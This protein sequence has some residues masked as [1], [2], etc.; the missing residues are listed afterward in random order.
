MEKNG[1]FEHIDGLKSELV[2][3]A[4]EIFDNP[5][6]GLE[7][8]F[9]SKLLQNK[10]CTQGFEVNAGYAGLETAFRAVWSNGQGGPNIGI[11]CEYDG[12]KGMGHT[13]GHHLQGP[14]AIGAATALKR[15]LEGTDTCCTITVYGTPAEETVG[16]KILMAAS[17]CFKE[18]DVALCT[19]AI[20]DISFVGGES[21]ALAPFRVVFQGKT[22]HASGAP[23]EVRSAMD[24]MLLAF[25]G[26]E[27]MREHVKD[28]T[29]VSYNIVSGT[30]SFGQDPSQAKA[31]ISLRTYDEGYLM[32]L[33]RRLRNII[34]GACLM[35]DTEADIEKRP[36]YAVRRPNVALGELARDNMRLAGVAHIAEDFRTSGGSTDFGNVSRIVPGALIYLE[37]CDA[38]AHSQAWYDAGKTE[39]AQRCLMYSA[40]TLAGMAYDLICQPQILTRVK[41]AGKWD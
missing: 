9:A 37:F 10:L 13:C 20:Q 40:K 22:G 33:E 2:G 31:S 27:F 8:R 38:P 28:G 21:L 17:G 18:L 7:E 32:E 16:G 36:V 14:A 15:T 35:T 24:A 23:H 41:E 19:H 30:G 6:Y 26:I 11:L 29:R 4:Y 25:N 39:A 34:A 3:I 1:L 12:V 5:E